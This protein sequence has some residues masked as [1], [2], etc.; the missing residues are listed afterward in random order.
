MVSSLVILNVKNCLRLQLDS[1]LLAVML[2][3]VLNDSIS[4]LFRIQNDSRA[5]AVDTV[6]KSHPGRVKN[7]VQVSDK[8][9]V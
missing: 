6:L 2:Y 9:F 7:T 8:C 4:Q 3:L 1:V 5:Q